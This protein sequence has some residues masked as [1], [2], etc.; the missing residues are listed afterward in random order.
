MAVCR[1]AAVQSGTALRRAEK[2]VMLRESPL[3]CPP[4]HSRSCRCLPA[5]CCR[6]GTHEKSPVA[7]AVDWIERLHFASSGAP[8][9]LFF[10]FYQRD[11]WQV[12]HVW[13][14]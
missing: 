8:S 9:H 12:L 2:G 14:G 3:A 1:C 11:T 7:A 6:R 4:T 13:G 10:S 5:R